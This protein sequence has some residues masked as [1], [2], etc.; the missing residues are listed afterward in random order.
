MLIGAFLGCDSVSGAVKFPS[1]E[2]FA[3]AAAFNLSL[4]AELQD[5]RKVFLAESKI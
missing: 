2:S 4:A 3:F 1:L 5:Q